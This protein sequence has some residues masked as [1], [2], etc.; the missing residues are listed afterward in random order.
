MTPPTAPTLMFSTTNSWLS[1]IIRWATRSKVSHVS[2][3]TSM[4]GVPV[5]IE[6]SG[7]GVRIYPRKRW[8]KSRTV[9]AEARFYVDISDEIPY[10][11]E[12]VGDR[13]DYAGLIGF[14][15]VLPLRWLGR[16]VKNP[17]GSSRAFICSELPLRLDREHR[18]PEWEGLDPETTTPED[19]LRLCRIG[20]SFALLPSTETPKEL[21]PGDENGAGSSG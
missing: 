5:V 21:P 10:A 6:A 19:L 4:Q 18:I 7:L 20:H 11:I 17:L 13:Y 1:R 12:F 2:I 9:V 14:L 15:V 3:G 16:K 8:A